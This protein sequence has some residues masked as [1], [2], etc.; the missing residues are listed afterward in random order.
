M[1][2]KRHRLYLQSR[3]RA[4]KNQSNMERRCRNREVS[5]AMKALNRSVPAFAIRRKQSN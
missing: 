5:V 3:G 1:K 4:G 2:E